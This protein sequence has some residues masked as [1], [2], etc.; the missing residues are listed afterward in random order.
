MNLRLLFSF[1]AFIFPFLVY[2][3]TSYPDLTFT[4]NGE[5]TAAAQ[6]LGIAHPSGYPLFTILGYLWLKLPL[7]LSVIRQLNIF[8]SFL[9]AISISIIFNLI[10]E[11]FSAYKTII[12][13]KHSYII[14]LISSLSFA[15]MGLVWEQGLYAEVYSLHLLLISITL[16]FSLKGYNNDENSST[17]YFILTSFCLGLSFSNHL[18]SFL[19][20]PTLLIIYF[21]KHKKVSLV[22]LIFIFLSFIIGLSL[23]LYLPLRSMSNP[24]FD[25]GGVSRSF[26]KFLYHVQ[27][28]Q[29]QVWLFTGFEA[30]KENIPKM[31]SAIFD[32][33]YIWIYIPILGLKKLSK[34]YTIMFA[35]LILI[36]GNIVYSLNYSIHDIS[37]Y[38]LPTL[39]VLFLMFALAL[40]AIYEIKKFKNYVFAIALLPIILI[41]INYSKYDHSE[42]YL[43]SEY[44][45]IVVDN[46][47]ENAIVIGA[48]WDYW[49]APFWYQQRIENKR[50]DVILIEKEL[51][52]RTWYPEQIIR[53]YPELERC[54]PEI[55][56]YMKNLEL[57]EAGLPYNPREIQSSFIN[58]LNSFID[59]FYNERPIYITFDMLETEKDVGR[60]YFKVPEGFAFR[61]YDS[62]RKIEIDLTTINL[63]KFKQSIRKNPN[64]L[65]EGIVSVAIGNLINIAFYCS[66]YD[67][68]NKALE[69]LE[70][71][72]DLDENNLLVRQAIINLQ[73]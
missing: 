16:L 34:N 30:M 47:E 40:T 59:K 27:G 9:T 13:V 2:L 1:I 61:L 67:Q 53:W 7:E 6:T 38:F 20:I 32:L 28:K 19:L 36:F 48:Q 46:L 60:N 72:R 15:F 11:L 73:R 52:R 68:K 57:F 24:E 64:H 17:K 23:Y 4:D 65:E 31:L 43:V 33:W 41:V 10:L 63:E 18:T 69:A 29:Y 62:P 58:M 21:S 5:L 55:E 70:M 25:W 44:T 56:K 45:N 14:A 51:L 37:H 42:D 50:K 3:L 71:A 35:L 39:L 49:N 66:R 12:D 22:S 26:D 54:R 8:S